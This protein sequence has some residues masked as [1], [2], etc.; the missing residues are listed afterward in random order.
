VGVIFAAALIA[1]HTQSEHVARVVADIVN[2]RFAADRNIK[3]EI[4]DIQGSLL[5]DI[6]IRDLTVTYTGGPSPR[7][8]L[9][10]PSAHVRY[11]L[12]S[13]VAGNVK[14]DSIEV[15]SPRIVVP[16]K[17]N[18]KFVYPAGDQSP[19]GQATPS[20]K[21][22]KVA[23]GKI[24]LRDVSLVLET[25][26]PWVLKSVAVR[27]AYSKDQER[28]TVTI[29]SADLALGEAARIDMISGVITSL[30]DRVEIGDL[31]VRTPRAG[32]EAAG[33]F[34]IGKNDSLAAKVSIDSLDLAELPTFLGK[35]KL[36]KAGS[37]K[38][39]ASVAGRYTDMAIGA[40]LSGFFDIYT[41]G[42]LVLEAAYADSSLKVKR[43]DCTVNGST[44]VLEGTLTVAA[45]PRYDGLLKFADLD[46]ARFVKTGGA[47]YSSGLGGSMRFSGKGFTQRD[48]MVTVWPDL[49]G[50]RYR[51]WGFDSIKG[52]IN[53]TPTEVA[54]DTLLAAVKETRVST[55]GKLGMD[56]SGRLDF[57]LD[58]PRLED[59]YGYH[60]VKALG[61]EV[62][63]R[64]AVEI[65]RGDLA[66]SA[67]SLGRGIDYAG[68]YLESLLVDVNLTR[69]A[70]HWGGSLGVLGSTVNMRG[71][72]AGEIRGDVVVKDTTLEIQRLAVTRPTGDLVGARGQIRIHKKDLFI[73]IDD[74][75]IQMADDMWQNRDPIQVAYV[76]ESLA[77]SSFDLFSEMGKV[78]L[79][80]S[81]FAA[82]AYRLSARVED[83]DLDRL[84]QVVGKEM[85]TGMLSLAL[86]ASG[87]GDDPHFDLSFRVRDGEMRSVKF[88]ALGG[89]LAYTKGNLAI[90]QIS[91]EENGGN[92]A[93]RGA[94]PLDLTPSRLSA[95]SKAGKLA[96]VVDDLGEVTIQVTNMDIS[97]LWPLAPPLTK[98]K[99][100]AD[101]EL[102]LS[103][104][105]DNPRVASRGRLGGAYYG[106]TAVGDVSWDLALR[107]STL[108][109]AGLGLAKDRE[110][111]SL[112]G[113][114]PLAVSVLPFSSIFPA[115]PMDLIL[116]AENGALD[117][118]CEI[119]PKFKVCSGTYGADLRIGGTMEDPT[120][121]GTVNLAGAR[122]RF[123]GV[124]Q[125]V[126]EIYLEAE[127]R[128]KRFEVTK[129]TAEKGA[130][131]AKGFFSLEGVRISDYDFQLAL[132]DLAITEFED[133][134][135]VLGGIVSVKALPIEMGS[136][137]P[138]IEGN[139]TVEEGEYY[140]SLGAG[141]GGG[142]GGAMGPEAAPTWIMNLG[143]EIPHDF[144]VRGS[145]IDAELQGSLNVK[146]GAEGLLVLGTMQT[147]RGTFYIYNND[148]RISKGEFRFADVKSL[149][150]V[151]ID[152]EATSRV[153]DERIDIAAKG[154]ME[155]L[156]VTATSESG[157]SETQ[158]FEALTL[159][160]GVA[161]EGV[162]GSKFFTDEFLRSWGVA[163][164]N[165]FGSGVARELRLD[166]FGV[167]IGDGSQGNVLSATRVT[168]GKYVSD[169]VYLQYTQALGSLY[170]GAG[171]LTQRGLAFPER[172]FQAEY[173]LSDRFSMEGEAGT[174]GGLGY[175]DVDLKFTYGY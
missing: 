92:V 137:V 131:K 11:D 165:R 174:V 128:G 78:S 1:I 120:F 162:G 8:L 126:E 70:G 54:V 84:R 129:M 105:R 169:K 144:W 15:V 16:R 93:I 10:V 168:F 77:V 149:K 108:E 61:G 170:G 52:R 110:T 14:I 81:V 95:L 119:F 127:A 73:T 146:K 121:T 155:N 67:T 80:N 72:K 19:T 3:V 56:G 31:H 96:E 156:D 147:I 46:L 30:A 62:T 142:G 40:D 171:K 20:G 82:G 167:E 68:A 151:Y 32:L 104:R 24:R 4:G 64:A 2:G 27:A 132:K 123:E 75:M 113:R 22:G 115:R 59:L 23:I 53:V 76:A 164:V 41:I 160:R 90:K 101:V 97:V 130:L 109:V 83:L 111:L 148:F 94:M 50:G 37:L 98:L 47:D 107:D 117:L 58:C 139:I 26:K 141:A 91:L 166:Q 5:R 85:P 140:Y 175:F 136:M 48:L 21:G 122:L 35:P 173:R 12:G 143:V 55:S 29:E 100:L 145:D 152:L 74:L 79:A 89:T 51:E 103:G 161:T 153:L 71:F 28:S 99:G 163:L 106:Q 102:T 135:V 138:S 124:P 159:R 7:V 18:G 158:I 125:D 57:A 118:L 33:V 172:Q 63:A 60:K 114:V 44:A 17:A 36:D 88:A 150:N 86:D 25:E 134:Y 87:T 38:G 66:I 154:S 42:G 49:G 13:L 34:G 6:Y 157:W 45:M 112:A 43:L 133:F 69:T 39:R 65:T 116:K 9:T